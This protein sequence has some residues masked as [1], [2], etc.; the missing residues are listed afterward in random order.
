MPVN[1]VA[2][3]YE[4]LVIGIR[5]SSGKHGWQESELKIT[6]HVAA[7]ANPSRRCLFFLVVVLSCLT[8]ICV[9]Y[10]VAVEVAG[11]GK[12]MAMRADQS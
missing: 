8:D 4:L 11:S 5:Q 2:L 1:F 7:N 12:R 10:P 3:R 9:H 6:Q